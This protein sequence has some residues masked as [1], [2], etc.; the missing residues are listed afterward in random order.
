ME[1]D[2]KKDILTVARFNEERPDMNSFGEQSIQ[3]V[4][5]TV[6]VLLDSECGGLIERVWYEENPESHNYRNA[7]EKNQIFEAFV[8]QT[9]FT[10]NLGNDFTQGSESFSMGGINGSFS[11]PKERDVIAP[12][13][14]KLLQNARVYELQSFNNP[15]TD[16]PYN[17]SP[18]PMDAFISRNIGDKRYL[19]IDQPDVLPGR[20]AMV[21]SNGLIN[22][23]QLYSV[24][25]ADIAAKANAIFD[26][27]NNI[28]KMITEFDVNYFGGLTREQTY[29]A[30]QASGM[31]WNRTFSYRQD[32]IVQFT[33][34]DNF[35]KFAES[36]ID[37][38]IGND[39][40]NSPTAWNILNS[41]P[42]DEEGIINQ[43]KPYIDELIS[44]LDKVDIADG[45]VLDDVKNELRL[46][47]TVGRTNQSKTWT[48]AQTFNGITNVRSGVNMA[49]RPTS[50]ANSNYISFQ[51]VNGTVWGIYGYGSS[52]NAHLTIDNRRSGGNI[53]INPNNNIDVVNNNIV[54][55]KDPTEGKHAAN[56]DYVDNAVAAGGGGS[57]D[58]TLAGDNTFTGNNR[59]TKGLV[60]NSY[61]PLLFGS[62][63]NSINNDSV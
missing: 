57:G 8:S 25:V 52:S 44:D 12:G 14:L 31:I 33:T 5:N 18:D 59:F 20:V 43:L 63:S 56:K 7:W 2:I 9:Q 28:Y 47:A 30:I 15:L 36:L 60:I 40:N 27:L 42:I 50:A 48:S 54:N 37:N 45:L 6:A 10:L 19:Q 46:D 35:L 39:P 38:N 55:L 32:F 62:T 17:M 21:S 4:I 41:Q 51:N 61:Q 49:L 34:P 23:E 29:F 24:P 53:I 3:S 1:K 58:V 11:R 22:F 26:P 16:I 13:V